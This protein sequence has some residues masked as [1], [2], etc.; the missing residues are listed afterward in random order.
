MLCIKELVIFGR[1]RAFLHLV[2][3]A[4]DGASTSS[5][6]PVTQE[7]RNCNHKN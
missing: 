1:R 7:F 4:L 5:L 3:I 6:S 2:M